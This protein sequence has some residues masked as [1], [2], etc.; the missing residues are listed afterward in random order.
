MHFEYV[1]LDEQL[2]MANAKVLVWS[3]RAEFARL[4]GRVSDAERCNAKSST[5]ARG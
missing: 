5:G 2:R 1:E 3:A 4:Q